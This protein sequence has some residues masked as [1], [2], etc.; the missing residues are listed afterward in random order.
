MIYDLFTRLM[1]GLIPLT[2]SFGEFTGGQFRHLP[3]VFSSTEKQQGVPGASRLSVPLGIRGR[4]SPAGAEFDEAK[5]SGNADGARP[6]RDWLCA[7][8]MAHHG[9]SWLI[10]TPP[11]VHPKF[12]IPYSYRI[13]S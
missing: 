6:A 10:M 7:V 1:P 13:N 11:R 4:A 8:I 12:L 5:S 3:D 2:R 9:S